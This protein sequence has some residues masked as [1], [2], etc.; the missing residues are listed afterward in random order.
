MCS[1]NGNNYEHFS[2]LASFTF[3]RHR[4]TEKTNVALCYWFLRATAN[5]FHPVCT[6]AQTLLTTLLSLRTFK[7]Q[8]M[9]SPQVRV[10]LWCRRNASPFACCNVNPER[11]RLAKA[12]PHFTQIQM[13]LLMCLLLMCL[14]FAVWTST[15]HA[16]GLFYF[17]FTCQ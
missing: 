14:R 13:H 6:H 9:T 17:V 12:Q 7:H 11:L 1:E 16:Y 15:Q 4:S 2:I 8:R 3:G 10:S 5:T